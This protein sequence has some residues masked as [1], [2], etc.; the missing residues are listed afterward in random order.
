MRILSRKSIRC[1]ARRYGNN[2]PLLIDPIGLRKRVWQVPPCVC[3]ALYLWQLPKCLI[4][5]ISAIRMFVSVDTNWWWSLRNLLYSNNNHR[6]EQYEIGK[7]LQNL[8]RDHLIFWM[9]LTSKLYSLAHGERKA[10][11]SSSKPSLKLQKRTFRTRRIAGFNFF[12]VVGRRC[13]KYI[14]IDTDLW[15]RLSKVTF[16]L[17]NTICV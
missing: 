16:Y 13:T 2:K 3:M 14:V 11:R 5:Y 15:E 4:I 1:A 12:A 6:Q 9:K 8:D 17:L 10:E 7:I